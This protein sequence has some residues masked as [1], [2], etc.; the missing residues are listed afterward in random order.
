MERPLLADLGSEWQGVPRLGE[1]REKEGIV[2]LQVGCRLAGRRPFA[3]THT[4][5]CTC[6]HPDISERFL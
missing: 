2:T 4:H 3:H 1:N 6:A 5:A